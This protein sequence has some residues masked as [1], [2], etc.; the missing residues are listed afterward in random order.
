MSLT[1]H[2]STT[3]ADVT[4]CLADKQSCW[5]RS[6]ASQVSHSA[7]EVAAKDNPSLKCWLPHLLEVCYRGLSGACAQTLPA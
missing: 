4:L 6:A 1:I 3:K 5:G 2:T 7:A